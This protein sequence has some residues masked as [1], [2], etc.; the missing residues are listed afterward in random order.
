[1]TAKE[2][3]E[4]IRTLQIRLEIMRTRKQNL[5]D[6]LTNVSPNYSDM[7]HSSTPNVHRMEEL[8]CAKIDIDNEITSASLELEKILKM[9]NSLENSVYSFIL[10]ERYI[11]RQPWNKIACEI[12]ICQ[13]HVFRY[14]NEALAEIDTMRANES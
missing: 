1:M 12:N 6:A 2:Y 4:Q 3:L 9:I 10:S 13:S 14:H 7:P 11:K 5:M 8:I